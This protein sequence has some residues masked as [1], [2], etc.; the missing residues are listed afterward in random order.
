MQSIRNDLK[1]S[2]IKSKSPAL[3]MSPQKKGFALKFIQELL[4]NQIL[5]YEK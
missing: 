2:K 3:K 1:N 4:K 5:L